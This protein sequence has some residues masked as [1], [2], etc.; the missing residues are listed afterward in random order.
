MR[1]GFQAGGTREGVWTE[2]LGELGERDS[3]TGGRG[4]VRVGGRT[5]V[6]PFEIPFENGY[7]RCC[8]AAIQ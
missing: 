7:I 3:H 2:E 5:E 4:R 1:E 6:I 8:S